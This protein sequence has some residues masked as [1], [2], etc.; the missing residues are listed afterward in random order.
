MAQGRR[1]GLIFAAASQARQGQG[2][3]GTAGYDKVHLGRQMVD[4][5]GDGAVDRLGVDDVAVVEHQRE[6]MRDGGDRAS[7]FVGRSGHWS[8]RER[9]RHV[10][11]L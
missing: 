4:K 8:V 2:W 11:A 1:G 10:C 6:V 3:V 7:V 9:Q 5:K